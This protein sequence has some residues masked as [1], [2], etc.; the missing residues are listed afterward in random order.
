MLWLSANMAFRMADRVYVDNAVSQK[1]FTRLFK[2]E[3]LLITLGADLR[4]YPG[5]DQLNSFGLT[6]E[7][8]ILFVGLLKRDKGVHI[9]IEA[10]NKLD[11]PL[12]LVIVG[13]CPDEP[14]YVQSLKEMAD[15]R[16][17]FLGYVYGEGAQQLFAN[18]YIYVQPSIMEGNSPSL[19]TA[20]SYGRCCLVSNIEQNLETIGDGGLSFRVNDALDL[21]R[22][23]EMLLKDESKIKRF[24]SLGRERI[25]KYYNW[26]GIVNQLENLCIELVQLR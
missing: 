1:I 13:D 3:P 22:L 9:L 25:E 14:K 2:K 12:P 17:H 4:A 18:C 6:E 5:S 16:V 10:Y 8:Y 19:M 23:L 26:N 20:M 15:N 11:T 24:G 21:L 7:K